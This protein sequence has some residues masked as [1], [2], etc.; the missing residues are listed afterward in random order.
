MKR[1]EIPQSFSKILKYLF[2]LYI[3]ASLL[4]TAHQLLAFYR[5]TEILK[6]RDQHPFST[7]GNSVNE[8]SEDLYMAKAFS[9]AMGPSKVIPYYMKARKIPDGEDI[10]IATQVTQDR[11]EVFSRLVTN[12][13]GPISVAIHVKN[14]S[15]QQKLLDSI[16][17][18]YADNPFMV[19]FVDIHLVMD[20]FERQFN[21]WRN[22]ARIYARTDYTLMLDVDF[23]VCTDFR[24][25]IRE[26]SD[27]QRRLAMGEIALVLPAFEF[28]A[29]EDG[30][31][32]TT[33]PAN[34]ESLIQLAHDGR[35]DMFHR[36]WQKGHQPTN[37]S[38]WYNSR[39]PY[40]VEAYQFNYEPYV[41]YKSRNAPW[42]DERFIG[43]GAN[44]AACLYEL[45]LSGVEYWVLPE[46]FLIHQTHLY[47]ESDRERERKYNRKLYEA[48]REEL[49]IRYMNKFISSGQWEK[50]QASNLKQQCGKIKG[51]NRMA[52]QLLADN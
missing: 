3:M 15:S 32:S 20:P 33:F 37:Y 41:I 18:L 25:A 38:K 34:K 2:L 23:H 31:D 6:I 52:K 14:D 16:R 45:Y 28:V 29:Q 49:C 17:D 30:L 11:F 1:I 51:F 47:P 4:Y 21:M 5:P 50:P 36:R 8:M 48:F 7:E 12:Y 40:R 44:K 9:S 46:D 24:R 19:E 39:E 22:V 27:I 26:N 10:T 42:C 13:Q 35:I 43:Y